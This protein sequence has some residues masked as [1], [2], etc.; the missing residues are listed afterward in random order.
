MKNARRL[1]LPC[2][3]SLIALF[4]FGAFLPVFG[5]AAAG[6]GPLPEGW[7]GK[8]IQA[9]LDI[10]NAPDLSGMDAFLRDHVSESLLQNNAPASLT[11]E[12]SRWRCLT[13]KV[14]FQGMRT[15]VP[16]PPGIMLAQVK[17]ANFKVP[18]LLVLRFGSTPEERMDL[19][20]LQP[21][22]SPA[23]SQPAARRLTL[24]DF[25]QEM[26]SLAR[27]LRDCGVFSGSCL[28]AR[29][30]EVLFSYVCGESNK[31]DHVANKLDTKFNLGSMNKMFTATAIAQLVEKGK[32]S[33][34]D[35]LDRYLD[36]TWLPKE[37]TSKV[38]IEQLLTHRS[39]LGSYFNKAFM[40]SSRDLYRELA[41]YK[42]LLKEEKLAFEPGTRFR[43]SNTGFLLLGAVV[44]KASGQNY[45][46]YIR[47]HVYEP[48][49]MRNSDC[50]ELDLPIENLAQ[51][52]IPDPT[53]PYGW[54]SN[55]FQ[56]VKRGG[57]AGGGYSTSPDLHRFALALLANR[58]VSA[59]TAQKLWTDHHGD[60]YGYGFG[61]TTGPGGREVGHSGG[62]AGLNSKL[63]IYLDKGVI[64]CVMS[65]FDQGANLL[66][67]L[68]GEMIARLDF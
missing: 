27:H 20:D 43:Y 25:R 62:F 47:Q 21:D 22:Q 13:G 39:G 41:D 38:T 49:G 4:F 54:R 26:A 42:P 18:W 58:L 1:P 40:E 33:L 56:H 65:N 7:K 64:V 48:A 44:E 34:S 46:D 15:D 66:A 12:I 14:E 8:H 6:K 29:K 59:E 37:V 31:A 45:F 10:L 63:A 53:T 2:T 24:A 55:I 3:L 60:R 5:Q 19:Y 57:P 68:A 32:V 35:T 50:Y 51:G 11:A 28:V 23:G 61:V 9:L 17:T 30:D 67:I 52:Y 16:A 36:E